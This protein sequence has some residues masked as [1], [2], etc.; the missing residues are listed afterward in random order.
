MTD[1]QKFNF[2]V[3]NYERKLMKQGI[4]KQQAIQMT[5]YA[6]DQNLP[7]DYESIIQGN[8]IY[9]RKRSKDLSAYDGMADKIKTNFMKSFTSKEEV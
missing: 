7:K 5:K 2:K 1:E 3:K 6:I 4:S 9:V 8:N